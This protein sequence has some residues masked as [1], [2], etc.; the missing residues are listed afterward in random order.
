VAALDLIGSWPVDHVAAGYLPGP[1]ADPEMAGETDRV[2][3]LASVTKLLTSLAVLVAVEEAS[4]ELDEPAMTMPEVTVRHLFAHASGLPF[5][6]ATPVA[7]P[8]RRRIYSNEG[9]ERLAAHVAERTG[10]PF[11]AY[12]DEA[13]LQPLGMH[14]TDLRDCSPAAGAWAPV[15]DVLRL[16]RELL[17]PSLVSAGTLSAAVTVQFPGLSGIVPGFGRQDPCDWGLGFE[18]RDGKSPHWTPTMASPA[19]FGH[20][21]GSGTFLW[22]DPVAGVA[23]AALTDRDFD[24]WA[25]EVWPPFGDAVLAEAG[26]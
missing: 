11:S 24:A 9:I 6:G 26:S 10:I 3:R 1:G 4:I 18:L 14:D 19:T 20:F 23:C 8:A 13:V 15:G 25:A 21:G 17:A 5:E 7:R 22:V 16:G 2:F 12:L